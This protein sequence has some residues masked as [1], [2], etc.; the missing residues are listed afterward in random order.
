[1]RPASLAATD[2]HALSWTI[3]HWALQYTPHVSWQAQCAQ[4]VLTAQALPHVLIEVSACLRLWGGL[5]ALRQR[6]D[7]PSVGI[8]AQAWGPTASIA[9]ARLWLGDFGREPVAIDELP[10]TA[11]AAAHP[12]LA[13]LHPMGCTRWGHLAA[14]PRGGITRRFGR[15]LLAALDQAYGKQPS[16]HTW[17]QPVERFAVQHELHAQVEQAEG[18]LQLAAYQLQLLQAWLRSRHW[19]VLQLKWIWL[20]DIRRHAP[21]QGELLIETAQPTQDMAHIQRLLSEQLARTELPS[22]AHSLALHCIRAE[23]LPQTSASLLP[24]DQRPGMPLHQFLERVASKLGP[25]AVRRPIRCDDHRPEAA[26]AWIGALQSVAHGEDAGLTLRS[27]R[28]G[29]KTSKPIGPTDALRP[30]WL[31]K[32]ALPLVVRHDKPYYQG[33]LTL[34]HG[35]ER[36]EVSELVDAFGAE[37]AQTGLDQARVGA[38]IRDYFVAWSGHAGLLW[39]Y[40]ERACA[41]PGWY[42][43]GIFG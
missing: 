18:L 26:Q 12:H 8:A 41:E 16:V 3:A 28:K 21:R 25:A 33:P 40:R 32:Q 36:I 38:V 43:H 20:L 30:P 27:T 35:P 24:Q 17:L 23:P 29:Q 19:G 11:L 34:M 22:P 13:T 1:M 37:R 6:L 2:A 10:L 4:P 14:L 15:E 39:V 31:L 42:L 7:D 5:D 9:Q